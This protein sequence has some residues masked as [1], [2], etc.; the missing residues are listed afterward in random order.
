MPG[1]VAIVQADVGNI[2]VVL[3]QAV[4]LDLNALDAGEIASRRVNGK[5][6]E[7]LIAVIVFDKKYVF[8]IA[9]PEESAD[10]ALGF[11]REQP[12][13]TKGMA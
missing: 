6:V 2:R 3:R 11:G 9:A 10:R 8:R 12:G 1:L 13:C 5:D 7:I 4:E